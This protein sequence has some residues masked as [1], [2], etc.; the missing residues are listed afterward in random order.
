MGQ[1]FSGDSGKY[2]S[3]ILNFVQGRNAR[4]SDQLAG[5][6]MFEEFSKVEYVTY[7]HSSYRYNPTFYRL[8]WLFAFVGTSCVHDKS[9]ACRMEDMIFSGPTIS[10]YQLLQHGFFLWRQPFSSQHKR[11][12]LTYQIMRIQSVCADERSP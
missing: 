10:C 4:Q 8:N 6:P 5:T 12:R 9:L 1:F 7:Y 3:E 11:N 2:F